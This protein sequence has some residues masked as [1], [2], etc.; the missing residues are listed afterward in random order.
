[1]IS[2]TPFIP[3]PN[4]P[5]TIQPS[6]PPM[7]IA[8]ALAVSDQN[9]RIQNNETIINP[10]LEES[11]HF[12]NFIICNTC[13][14]QTTDLSNQTFT[15]PQYIAPFNNPRTFTPYNPNTLAQSTFEKEPKR[16]LNNK[17]ENKQTNNTASS[18][19]SNAPKSS[20]QNLNHQK[21]T[22]EIRRRRQELQENEKFSQKHN[23]ECCIIS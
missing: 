16:K 14:N 6:A 2:K 20:K 1:M 11:I 3:N 8:I 12:N 7:P 15:E 21:I 17:L 18:S 23:K 22:E 10:H 5:K 9:I 13:K 19:Q 4:S